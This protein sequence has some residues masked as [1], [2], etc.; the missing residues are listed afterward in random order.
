ML[1]FGD[2]DIVA[3]AETWL[4]P[5]CVAPAVPGFEC[6]QL[7][8]QYM[9]NRAV[10][11]SGGLA[12]YYAQRLASKVSVWKHSGFDTALW[13]KVDKSV[14]LRDDL[15]LA[16]CYFPPEGAT[17]YGQ[18]DGPIE[19]DTFQSL[20]DDIQVV[21]HLG[22]YLLCGDFNARTSS[23]HDWLDSEIW[24]HADVENS[25]LY[26]VAQPP[27]RN[28]AG[29]LHSRANNFGKSFIEMCQVTETWILN[30][31]TTGDIPGQHTCEANGGNSVVDYFLAPPSVFASLVRS[32]TVHDRIGL[33]WHMSDHRALEVLLN[34][35]APCNYNTKAQPVRLATKHRYD[36]D[37]QS[38]LLE[39]LNQP[40]VLNMLELLS[41]D[42]TSAAA[43]VDLLRTAVMHAVD[44][45]FEKIQ[46][47]PKKQTKQWYDQQCKL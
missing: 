17:F 19:S 28:N 11:G 16:T 2:A 22:H 41:A 12:V 8:R 32:L 15:Y 27:L 6:L 34:L 45:T 31:R 37:L 39:N 30:G 23:L 5:G 20:I 29:D 43:A 33:R 18:R 24:K 42:T 25:M 10:K 36:K 26:E 9:H 13:V 7:N 40:V 46:Q 38:Q 44:H 14:G 1:E 21:S 47:T 4:Q 3:V 35:E